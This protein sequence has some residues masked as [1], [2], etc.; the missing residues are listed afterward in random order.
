MDYT[1]VRLDSLNLTPFFAEATTTATV[2]VLNISIID[3]N[4]FEGTESFDVY[5]DSQSQ[6]VTIVQNRSEVVIFDDGKLC[7]RLL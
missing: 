3:D 2:C 4:I 6:G 1:S 5:L 7:Y